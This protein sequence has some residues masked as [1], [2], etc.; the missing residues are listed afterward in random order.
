MK[1][2]KTEE[3]HEV[4]ISADGRGMYVLTCAT[5]A[6]T[7]AYKLPV[8]VVR[9][10]LQHSDDLAQLSTSSCPHI[11]ADCDPPRPCRRRGGHSGPHTWSFNEAR[12]LDAV[13]THEDLKK[14][15]DELIEALE[16]VTV[17]RPHQ[18]FGGVV[19]VPAGFRELAQILRGKKS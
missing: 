16:E 15:R 2:I 5:S 6:G 19:E 17:D 9:A 13:V 7:V 8:W 12:R 4:R 11:D 10:L 18:G 3:G 1:T 14:L